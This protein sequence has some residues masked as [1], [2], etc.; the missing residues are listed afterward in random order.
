MKIFQSKGHSLDR[1][2]TAM[3][4]SRPDTD[5]YGVVA[6]AQWAGY[7]GAELMDEAIRVAR[8]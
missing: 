6:M 7:P 4:P 8:L 2:T 3:T 1:V 5:P